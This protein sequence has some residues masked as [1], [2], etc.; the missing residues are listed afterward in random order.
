MNKET[1]TPELIVATKEAVETTTGVN[2]SDFLSAYV[3]KNGE[4]TDLTEK[5][6]VSEILEAGDYQ[7]EDDATFEDS[8]MI[9]AYAMGA[10]LGV[11]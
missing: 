1:L 5:D 6:L 9:G 3:E 7:A 4:M 8:V 11:L 2:F 10:D